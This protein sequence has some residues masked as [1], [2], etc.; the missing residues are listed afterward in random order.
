MPTAVQ[1]PAWEDGNPPSYPP[2]RGVAEADVCV[3]GLGG[4]GLTALLEA[5]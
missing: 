5:E 4:T 1:R 3:I 2:L